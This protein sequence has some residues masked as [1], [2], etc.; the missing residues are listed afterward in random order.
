MLLNKSTWN[1]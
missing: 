1:C